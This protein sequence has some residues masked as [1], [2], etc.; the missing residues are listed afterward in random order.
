MELILIRHGEPDYSEVMERK[1]IGHV[2]FATNQLFCVIMI[3][4]IREME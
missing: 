4:R 2:N 3:Y 1:C